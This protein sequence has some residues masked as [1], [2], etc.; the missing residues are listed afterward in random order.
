MPNLEQFIKK[1]YTTRDTIIAYRTAGSGPPLLL[2]H[3]YPQTMFMWHL[4]ADRLAEDFTVV[5]ADLRGYGRRGDAGRR[6]V[7]DRGDAD[8][9]WC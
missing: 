3:G 1:T 7:P 9:V 6:R 8:G 2:L 4:V 5:M